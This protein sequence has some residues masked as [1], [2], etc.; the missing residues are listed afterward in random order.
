MG[1]QNQIDLVGFQIPAGQTRAH[2]VEELEMAGVDENFF[3]PLDQVGIGIVCL[4]IV[5]EKG[6]KAC[7]NFH[8]GY[9][10]PLEI[11]LK[12]YIIISGI[13][14]H[15]NP[16]LPAASPVQRSANFFLPSGGN[17]GR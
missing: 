2:V 4:W 11:P 17:N 8:K 10:L 6:M 7:N 3:G 13:A 15:S 12:I 5:P 9:P 16:V 1:D 14:N